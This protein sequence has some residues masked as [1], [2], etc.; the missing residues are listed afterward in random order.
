MAQQPLITLWQFKPALG[1]PNASPFCMKVEV[2]LRLAGLRYETRNAL[3]PTKGP[4][5]KLPFVQ[6]GDERIPDSSAIVE[7]L[8]ARYGLTLDRG[9]DARTRA[10]ARALTRMLEEHTYWGLIYARWIDPA[11]WDALVETFFG[12]L[13]KPMRGFV[14][15]LARRKVMR[16]ARGQGLLLHGR[17]EIYRR[18]GQD[19]DALADYLGERPFFFGDAPCSHDASVY[20][21]LANMWEATLETPLKPLVAR[22][23]NLVAYC[24]RMRAHCFA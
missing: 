22:H 6:I 2:F 7:Q 17:D 10:E 18:G 13:P 4:L 24:A 16:D 8:S 21:F 11:H 20:A 3:L 19:I 15:R 9:L 12:D 1:L 23:A 14:A 5:G